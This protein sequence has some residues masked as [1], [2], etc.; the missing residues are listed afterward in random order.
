MPHTLLFPQ[1]QYFPLWTWQN[2]WPRFCRTSDNSS[3]SCRSL[4]F[5]LIWNCTLYIKDQ[6]VQNNSYTNNFI[7]QPIFSTTNTCW[8]IWAS[9][10]TSLNYG[11]AL[12]QFPYSNIVLSAT[13]LLV[14][15]TLSIRNVFAKKANKPQSIHWKLYFKIDELCRGLLQTVGDARMRGTRYPFLWVKTV[16]S[17]IQIGINKLKKSRNIYAKSVFTYHRRNPWQ[18]SVSFVLF[19]IFN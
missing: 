2:V 13:W 6:S 18:L 9:T 10:T 16:R 5:Q 17:L 1:M 19:W 12:A 3:N 15:L 4:R 14:T 11:T 7:L 8:R